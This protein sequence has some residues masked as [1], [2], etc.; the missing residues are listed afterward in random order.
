MKKNWTMRVA[1][2]IVALAL[3]TS[4]FVSGTYAKYVTSTTA[5]DSARVAKFGVQLAVEVTA[6]SQ[7]SMKNTTTPI[8][9]VM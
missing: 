6:R 3:I 8:R 2:L 4:C 5:S 7:T 1:L 9:K